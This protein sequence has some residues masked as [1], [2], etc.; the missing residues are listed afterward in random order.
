MQFRILATLAAS[1]IALAA[2]GQKNE[3]ADVATANSGVTDTNVGL[4]ADMNASSTAAVPTGGQAFANT[5]A[6]SDAFE[7]AT[8]QLAQEKAQSAAVKKFAGQMITA[9]TESTAKLKS[10]ASGLATPITPDP[11]LTAQ[12]QSV[13][14]D[15][16][17]KT[18]AAFDQAYVAGQQAG[19]QQ[20][21]DA[22]NTYAA[23]GDVAELKSFAAGLSP[24]VAAHLNMAKGL[25]P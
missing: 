4:P 17:S 10:V 1:A 22:L 2:C 14:D 19:H 6:A 9:H 15:L 16:R 13:L 7:I 24:T 11:T 18:G 23:N 12:Q 8:S 5:A 25:K 20:T 3:N 21:L